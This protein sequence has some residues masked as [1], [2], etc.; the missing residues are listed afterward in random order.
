VTFNHEYEFAESE[1]SVFAVVHVQHGDQIGDGG[2]Q[3]V[4]LFDICRR[5]QS[6]V[7]RDFN[8]ALGEH[9]VDEP[10]RRRV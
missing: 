3:R 2:G 8:D 7:A 5:R 9:V 6:H 4:R 1:A 10:R